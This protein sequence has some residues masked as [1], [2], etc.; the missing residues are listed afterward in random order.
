MRVEAGTL[1]VIGCEDDVHAGSRDGLAQLPCGGHVHVVVPH[2]LE[3]A[4]LSTVGVWHDDFEVL[5]VTGAEVAL[6]DAAR[7]GGVAGNGPGTLPGTVHVAVVM[8]VMGETGPLLQDDDF[9]VLVVTGAEVALDDAV[10]PGGVAG[11]GLGTLPGAVHVAVVMEVM[12]ETGPLQ[13]DDFEVLVVTGAEVALDD[14]VR[15][16][17][18]AG[19]GLGTLP[20][21]VHVAVVMEVMDETGPLQDDDFEVLVVTGPEVTLNDTTR[22]GG[23]AGD[24]LATLPGSRDV[25]VVMPPMSEL[26]ALKSNNLEVSV[27]ATAEIFLDDPSGPAAAAIDADPVSGYA[28]C[29]LVDLT[30]DIEDRSG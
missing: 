3:L 1:A 2:V 17:G 7:P 25:R 30:F 11:N 16:G 14:A 22:P 20:G 19:N 10:R 4:G 27:A 9:E 8:E 18:V 28:E 23:V 24:S 15:P 12:G 13:D 6:D 26:G 5:V 21:A 29:L